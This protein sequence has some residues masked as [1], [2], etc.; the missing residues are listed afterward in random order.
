MLGLDS[1][2]FKQSQAGW[3]SALALHL[4]ADDKRD[5]DDMRHG[6]TFFGWSGRADQATP[7]HR[8]ELRDEDWVESTRVDSG[9]YKKRT[10]CQHSKQDQGLFSPAWRFDRG[11]RQTGWADSADESILWAFALSGL[12]FG[13]TRNSL[14]GASSE[15]SQKRKK[16][17]NR[18][19]DGTR[20][21]LEKVCASVCDCGCREES[22]ARR[23]DSQ[24]MS[25][26]L[27]RPIQFGSVQSS[28]VHLQ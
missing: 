27:V 18:G 22:C 20:V 17:I 26:Y 13:G 12:R 10:H 1:M 23:Q 25:R 11:H 16:K 21:R 3:L 15:Q 5:E 9:T 24:W 14:L 6:E 28:P 8:A 2:E 7:M 4:G 19:L